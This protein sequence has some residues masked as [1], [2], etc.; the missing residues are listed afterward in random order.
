MVRETPG[1]YPWAH[2]AYLGRRQR[3]AGSSQAL[4]QE[5]GVRL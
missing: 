3:D 4:D 1:S 5:V 2:S